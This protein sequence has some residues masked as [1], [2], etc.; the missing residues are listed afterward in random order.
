MGLPDRAKAARART[1]AASSFSR[2]AAI[3]KAS[4]VPGE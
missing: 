1:A 2:T 4:S 3:R